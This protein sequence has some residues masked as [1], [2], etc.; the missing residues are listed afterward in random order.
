MKRTNG[1]VV[2]ISRVVQYSYARSRE[3][4]VDPYLFCA[5]YLPQTENSEEDIVWRFK[6]KDCKYGQY[7]EYTLRGGH[8]QPGL[9]E[10]SEK[11]TDAEMT[12]FFEFELCFS[13]FRKLLS[14]DNTLTAMAKKLADSAT[15]D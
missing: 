2:E 4:G 15:C 13:Q 9:D 6:R 8:W 7:S 14:W 5:E 11:F 10:F 1:L 3:L 12:L